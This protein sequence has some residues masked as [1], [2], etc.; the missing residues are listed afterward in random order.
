MQKNIKTQEFT[1]PHP[2]FFDVFCAE[3][4]TRFIQMKR[5]RSDYTIFQTAQ[6]LTIIF[7][8]NELSITPDKNSIR[9]IWWEGYHRFNGQPHPEYPLAQLQR[10]YYKLHVQSAKIYR[11][12]E[13]QHPFDGHKLFELKQMVEIIVTAYL[14]QRPAPHI[15]FWQKP[16]E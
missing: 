2:Q 1:V 5:N 14:K 8:H 15:S 13:D 4:I 11:T 16:K 3:V 6:K 7:Q 10:S 12:Y 9:V